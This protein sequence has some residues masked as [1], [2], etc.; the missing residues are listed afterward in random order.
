MGKSAEVRGCETGSESVCMHI[1]RWASDAGGWLWVLVNGGVCV[2]VCGYERVCLDVAC[3]MRRWVA[4][5]LGRRVE[6]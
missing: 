4:G 6:R 1:S 3:R 2:A 5:K